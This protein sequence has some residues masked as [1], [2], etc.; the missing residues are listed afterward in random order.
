MSLQLHSEVTGDALSLT[1]EHDRHQK[2]DN[3]SQDGVV[4]LY[5]Y[6]HPPMYVHT[7]QIE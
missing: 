5:R 6:A 1:T 4:N 2:D 7:Q 3:N